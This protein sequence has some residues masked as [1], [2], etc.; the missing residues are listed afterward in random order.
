MTP[1]QIAQV[2]HSATRRY[3]VVA[4]FPSLPPWPALPWSTKQAAI[5][6]VVWV[7]ENPKAALCA[8]H[9]TWRQ[10]KIAEGWKYGPELDVDNQLHPCMVPYEEMPPEQHVKDALFRAIV[11]ALTKGE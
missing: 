6:G 10:C 1:E 11:Q 5:A 3:N 2:C 7:Q 9:E 8:Q 4:G